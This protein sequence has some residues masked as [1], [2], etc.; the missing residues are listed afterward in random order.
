MASVSLKD[1]KL[2]EED[3][4]TLNADLLEIGIRSVLK[5]KKGCDER[6]KK[7]FNMIS[8]T[9]FQ[10]IASCARPKT[11]TATAV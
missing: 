5:G 2:L 6:G 7:S 10:T 9:P 4:R 11:A 8:L 3:G 1:L